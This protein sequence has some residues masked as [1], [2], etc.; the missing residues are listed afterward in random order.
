M[1]PYKLSFEEIHKV[2]QDF[3]KT[4]F[5]RR[6][7]VFSLM[8]MFVAG[9]FFVFGIIFSIIIDDLNIATI[10]AFAGAFISYVL[11]CFTQLQY[12]ALLKDY[13]KSLDEKTA[14]KK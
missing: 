10:I 13:I 9:I 3:N 1:N 11:G 14:S 4:G 7:Y 5:G 6:A 8:P 12:G 2:S